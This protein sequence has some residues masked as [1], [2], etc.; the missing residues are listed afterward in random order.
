MKTTNNMI[1]Q[2]ILR[3]LPSKY[4]VQKYYNCNLCNWSWKNTNASTKIA[5]KYIIVATLE[6][7]IP[8][9]NATLLSWMEC[10]YISDITLRI[11]DVLS[12][13]AYAENV[14]R[15]YT[16]LVKLVLNFKIENSDPVLDIKCIFYKEMI[17]HALTSIQKWKTDVFNLIYCHL[18]H[19]SISC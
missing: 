15:T 1:I 4:M 10:F 7:I 5:S 8:Q 18:Y 16:F 14:S 6:C 13:S 12:Y 9:S 2:I 17:L 3:L 11:Q 19:E